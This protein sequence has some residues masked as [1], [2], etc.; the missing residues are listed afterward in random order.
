VTPR[1]DRP[2][3]AAR[4]LRTSWPAASDESAW[5]SAGWQ[6]YV[7]AGVTGWSVPTEYGGAGW[8]SAEML[9]GCL[10]LARIELTPA[11]VLTQFQAAIGR[12]VAGTRPAPKA[13][14]LRG[15]ADGSKFATVGISHL[16]TSRQ[17]TTPAVQATADGGGYIVT[18]EIP[19]VTGVGQADL[20]VAGATLEDGRQILF[21]LS[22]NA[23]GVR[24]ETPAPLLA[25]NGSLTG[26]V[27]L[28][29]AFIALDDLISDPAAQVLAGGSGPGTGSYM[30]SATAL[31][32][33]YGC[34]DRIEIEADRRPVL[35]EIVSAFREDADQ[36]RSEL[37]AAARGEKSITLTPD[38][39]RTRATTLALNASQAYLTAAKGAGFVVGHPAERMAREALFFLVWSCPQTVSS[40]L[41][42]GFS[43]CDDIGP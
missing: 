4:T 17:H 15:L 10:E 33:A 36:L 42:Q 18:G 26:P 24:I 19:W 22:R 37:L 12:I 28:E 21:A 7:R 38:A 5:P 1:S 39:A 40:R 34:I 14:W 31:G 2:V 11:F 13:R 41:L 29:N 35:N 23:E 30:T 9:E 8:S 32:H 20:I 43:Q 16:T 3:E 25:L 27:R 6:A